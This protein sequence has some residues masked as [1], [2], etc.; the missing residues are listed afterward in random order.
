M[1]FNTAISKLMEY[2][3]FLSRESSRPRELVEP[4]VLLVAPFAPH[5]AE[6]LWQTLGHEA[7]LAY[8]PWPSFDPALCA[9]DEIEVVVQVNNKGRSKIVVP[10]GLDDDA[11]IAA[12]QADE[13]T[14]SALAGKQVVKSFV[15]TSRNG[16]LVNFVIKG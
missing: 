1:R 16:K 15:V 9:S 3:N 10:A 8:E 5:Q 13:K 4:L 12:A 14:A 6:E 2:V 11:V 7:T